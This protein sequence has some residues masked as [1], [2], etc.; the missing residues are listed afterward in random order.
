MIIPKSKVALETWL[1]ELRRTNTLSNVGAV[2]LSLQITEL[3][4]RCAELRKQMQHKAKPVTPNRS[5]K[6]PLRSAA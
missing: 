1:A 2:F 3:E 5:K 6:R 4:N